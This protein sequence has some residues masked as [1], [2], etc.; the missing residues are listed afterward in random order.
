MADECDGTEPPLAEVLAE[1]CHT[2][3]VIASRPREAA[4]GTRGG[5]ALYIEIRLREKSRKKKKKD[6]QLPH[7]TASASS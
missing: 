1:A 5:L 6:R 4:V 3:P 7:S 2:F